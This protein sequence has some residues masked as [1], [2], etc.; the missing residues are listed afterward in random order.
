M[1]PSPSIHYPVVLEDAG[2]NWSGWVPDLPG[3]VA[4]AVNQSELISELQRAILFHLEGLA[5]DGVEP[6]QPF[7]DPITGLASTDIVT[8]VEICPPHVMV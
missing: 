2:T 8:W 5:E 3:C 6:P 4:T 7:Q 1:N